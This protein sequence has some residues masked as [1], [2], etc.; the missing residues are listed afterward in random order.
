[1]RSPSGI[2][3]EHNCLTFQTSAAEMAAV[4]AQ[5]P[6]VK[7]AVYHVVLSW[8]SGEA[9]TDAEAFAC[10][11]HA[12][13][14]VGMEG[15][16][17]LFAVHRD[18]AHA[19]LHIAVNRVHPESLR[20]VYPD[21]DFF[22]LDRAMR[23]L[24]L[25]YGWKHDKGP[26]A[27]F[28]RGG[29]TVIDWASQAPD[30]KGKRPT[31]ASD[32]ERHAD[33]ES[34]F[35]YVRGRPR[36]Q[37]LDLLKEEAV[38]WQDLHAVLARHGLALREKGQGLAVYDTSNDVDVPVKASD[39]HESLSKPRLVARLGPY[40]AYAAPRAEATPQQTY[41][42][43]RPVKRDPLKRERARQERA[44]AR[45][46]LRERYE[47]YRRTFVYRRLDGDE[48]KR[49]YAELR[50]AARARREEVKRGVRDAAARKALYSVIAFETLR[51]RERL[52]ADIAVE[53]NGLKV[54]PSN[55]RLSYRAWVEQQAALG[56]DAAISQLRGWAYSEQRQAARLDRA[57][58]AVR[59][60]FA[61]RGG[62]DPLATDLG[63]GV[64][65]AVRR[66]GTVVYRSL[67][68]DDLAIDHGERVEVCGERPGPDALVVARLL[69]QRKFGEHLRPIGAESRRSD[70]V[71]GA[72][73]EASPNPAGI[74]STSADRRRR[75]MS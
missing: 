46:G 75:R 26:Y 32:M 39:M 3:C 64:R 66:D 22:R 27:V 5:N 51:N 69:A 74:A 63:G 13:R 53:R 67:S 25:Q 30:T 68:G 19:H 15:H 52:R 38:T 1:M 16:Q 50:V 10:G 29:Q 23:E 43:H 55:H 9:P 8:P 70:Q 59:E 35:T 42:R 73:A 37:V 65:F 54:D 21:R 40:H 49:R 11:R 2:A 36:Q 45:R 20:A 6:R 4:A 61:G 12:V 24:E 17:Y 62:E 71:A 33:A 28:E 72:D 47:E 18:T 14:A 31:R 34:L 60:G 7:D 56:D 58:T 48:V 44:D 41:D 57:A